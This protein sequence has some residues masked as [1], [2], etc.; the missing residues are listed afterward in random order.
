MSNASFQKQ[1]N[2]LGKDM[3]DLMGTTGALVVSKAGD[4]KELVLDRGGSALTYMTKAIKKNPIAA[5]GI[6]FGLG[7]VV[8]GVMR[9]A[10][11]TAED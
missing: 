10:R 8:M 5:V 11:S 7:V 3:S 2:T 6:A 4:A 1:I 9:L